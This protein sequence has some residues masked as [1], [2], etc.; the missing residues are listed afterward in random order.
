MLTCMGAVADPMSSHARLARPLLAVYYHLDCLMCEL[1]ICQKVSGP[2]ANA[3]GGSQEAR[4]LQGARE[5][6]GAVWWLQWV[7]HWG[8]VGSTKWHLQRRGPRDD[9]RGPP[10]Y[11][12]GRTR[13]LNRRS[14]SSAKDSEPGNEQGGGKINNQKT[15]QRQSWYRI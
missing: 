1:C 12:E 7:S 2:G 4:W 15:G 6:R 10:R 5:S 11:H 3:L 9:D 13:N 8:S 14:S